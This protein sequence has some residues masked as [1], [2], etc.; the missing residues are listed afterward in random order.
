MRGKGIWIELW[1]SLSKHRWLRTS[2]SM[3][4]VLFRTN[5]VTTFRK[6]T[7][8][9]IVSSQRGRVILS[10]RKISAKKYYSTFWIGQEKSRTLELNLI[11]MRS[12]KKKM[13][14]NKVK[15]NSCLSRG[16]L[17]LTLLTCCSKWQRLENM[18]SILMRFLIV[19][20]EILN[21]PW[22]QNLCKA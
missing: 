18:Q 20:L 10:K 19:Q 4:L 9:W 14:W 1:K 16:R 2:A 5:I 22:I 8:R 13:K 21:K 15:F 7:R 17:K 3:I 11:F 6:T 12:A